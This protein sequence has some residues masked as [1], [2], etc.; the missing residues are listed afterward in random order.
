VKDGGKGEVPL[1]QPIGLSET[2]GTKLI[3]A[4]RRARIKTPLSSEELSSALGVKKK[5]TIT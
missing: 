5:Y 3:L 2:R 4:N 1:Q